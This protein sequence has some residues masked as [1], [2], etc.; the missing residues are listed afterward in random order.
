MILHMKGAVAHS[1]HFDRLV[2]MGII[3]LI[4]AC[5]RLSAQ[6]DTDNVLLMGRSAIGADDYLTAIHYFNQV[7]EAKPFLHKPYY[8]RAYAKFSL[9]D[10]KGA[11]DDCSKAI[12]RNPYLVEVYQ[13]RGLCR[14]HNDDLQGAIEDYTRVL[15]ELPEEQG[16]MYNRGLCYLQLDR[17][18]EASND[19]AALLKRYPSF[20]RAYMVNV[21]ICLEKTDTVGALRWVDELLTHNQ[22]IVEAWSFKGRYALQKEQFAEADTFLTKAIALQPTHYEDYIARALAR[23][24]LNR[25]SEAI[26]DYDKTIELVPEHFVAHYNRGLLL[27]L[28]GDNNKAIEDFD[29]IISQEPD[30]TLAIYNRALLRQETGDY[31]GAIADFTTLI[32]QYPNFTYGYMARAE[33]R[34]KVGDVRGAVNDESVVARANL[35]VTFGQQKRTPVKKVR[36]RSEHSLDQYQQ[37]VD[38]EENDSTG[39]VFGRLFAGELFGRVQNKKT[40]RKLM[41]PFELTFKSAPSERGYRSVAF[42]PE[43][44]RL[45]GKIGTSAAT[46]TFSAE[47]ATSAYSATEM[48]FLAEQIFAGKHLAA[49][50]SLTL[51]AVISNDNYNYA[52]ALSQLDEAQRHN[53]DSQTLV[54]IRLQRASILYRT[55]LTMQT[56]TTSDAQDKG[57]EKVGV[58]DGLTPT[59]LNSPIARALRELVEAQ[60]QSTKNQYVKYNQGCIYAAMG[61]ATNAI[62]HFTAAIDMDGRLAEAYFNRGLL[63]LE[64][65]DKT[66]AQSDLSRAGELGLYRAYALL[67]Q[68]R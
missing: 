66:R 7:I 3:W 1:L 45:A 60:N 62:A 56:E 33:C 59:D 23:H 28:I 50:D 35:D 21:Q 40:D 8:Y 47:H 55:Y 11:E 48:D 39:S 58:E 12:S 44:A 42:L 30:N 31:R 43:A 26:A 68:A 34:R 57:K 36:S 25:F 37:L 51:Q 14:I 64:Q 32:K 16:A 29:Y 10:Y 15:K 17:Y 61:D 24:Y 20:Y 27:A 18:D 49:A 63:Y 67:K 5:G 65:G 46:L 2:T 54:L 41:P 4:L 19:M 22:S 53:P 52:T 6:I 13:L 9:E 38:E